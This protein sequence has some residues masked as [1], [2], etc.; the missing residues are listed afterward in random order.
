MLKHN[1]IDG[2]MDYRNM[3]EPQYSADKVEIPLPGISKDMLTV[4]K[5]EQ[6]FQITFNKIAMLIRYPNEVDPEDVECKLKD[7]LLTISWVKSAKKRHHI[8]S[9][10]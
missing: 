10:D 8:F 5:K 3:L 2:L 6:H 1:D 9:V 4:E 7:G